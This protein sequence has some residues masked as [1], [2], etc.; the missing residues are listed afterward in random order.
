VKRLKFLNIFTMKYWRKKTGLKLTVL[1]II[2]AIVFFL[3]QIYFSRNSAS[4]KDVQQLFETVIVP[5][6]NGIYRIIPR[7]E[8]EFRRIFIKGDSFFDSENY[9]DAYLCYSKAYDYARKLN[10]QSLLLIAAFNQGLTL[11]YWGDLKIAL[12]KFNEFIKNKQDTVFLAEAFFN[13]ANTQRLLQNL[14]SAIK[15]YSKVINLNPYYAEAYNNRGV[16]FDDMGDYDNALRDYDKAIAIDPNL[17]AAYNNR[18]IIFSTKHYDTLAI[19][20]F[21]KAIK[22]NP[23]NPESYSNRG[24]VYLRQRKYE[25]AALDYTQAISIKHNDRLKIAIWYYNRSMAYSKLGENS[26]TMTD[27]DSAIEFNPKYSLA[28]YARGTIYSNMDAEEKAYED[29]SSAIKYDK[30]NAPAYYNRG[31][32]YLNK[33]D[34]KDALRDYNSA[35]KSDPNYVLPYNN[36]GLIYIDMGKPNEA[37]RDFL[38]ILQLDSNNVNAMVNLGELYV[39]KKNKIKA[40]YWLN[41]ALKN[42]NLPKDTRALVLSIL[43]E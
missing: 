40:K 31:N 16:T 17:A 4:K 19:S 30:K 10:R 29:F 5:Y 27:L 21:S 25:L 24:F 41:E 43:N 23:N 36:R 35:I 20:D 9:Q 15:D 38:K 34:N 8:F 12:K 13:R 39:K 2:L 22:L 11:Y 26:K 6:E 7:D 33:K 32:Y 18:G 3:I 28:Y 1:A 14:Q 42:K 37:E